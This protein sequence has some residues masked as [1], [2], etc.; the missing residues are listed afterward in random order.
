MVRKGF[1]SLQVA[2]ALLR[3][4]WMVLLFHLHLHMLGKAQKGACSNALS[5]SRRLS[6]EDRVIC[7]ASQILETQQQLMKTK[8]EED[9][10][11][12]AASDA[13]RWN[14]L[15]TIVEARAL[16][17]SIFKVAANQ[18]AQ[19]SLVRYYHHSSIMK[20]CLMMFCLIHVL[21]NPHST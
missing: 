15:R 10:K 5:T 20:A 2:F 17:K 13:R 21:P 12:Q 1:C 3:S 6:C 16:L 7:Y 11:S 14:G 4:S 18:K 9:Q 8:A 19:A